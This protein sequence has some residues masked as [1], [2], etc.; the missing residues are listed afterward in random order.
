MYR[1]SF[2]PSQPWQHFSKEGWIKHVKNKIHVSLTSWLLCCVI[3]LFVTQIDQ[4]CL[5]AKQH[6]RQNKP[7]VFCTSNN[8]TLT[9]THSLILLFTVR[10]MS[11]APD[12]LQ[13]LAFSIT[14]RA[15]RPKDRQHLSYRVVSTRS[16][17]T[18]FTIY[19]AGVGCEEH[20]S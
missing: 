15:N 7:P 9:T 5:C 20:L 8:N 18:L 11:G 6:Q 3:L 14:K 1:R 10:S 2:A 17:S 16:T 12:A 13:L 4:I 19:S